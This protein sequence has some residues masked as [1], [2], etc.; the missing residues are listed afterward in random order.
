MKLT[1]MFSIFHERWKFYDEAG[2][3]IAERMTEENAR[4]IASRFNAID[5]IKNEMA[6][7]CPIVPRSAIER[8]QT[9]LEN[10]K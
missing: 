9:I 7:I 10:T 4:L 8:I 5:E 1:M 6:S 3:L 2:N